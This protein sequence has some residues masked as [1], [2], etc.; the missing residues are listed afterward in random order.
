M[1][2]TEEQYS[3]W[4]HHLQSLPTCAL[5]TTGRTGSDFLQ[6]LLD[7]HPQV[8][9]FNGHFAVY[10]EFFSQST[11]LRAGSVSS[12]DLVDEFVGKYIYKLVSRYDIQE[13]KD[14]L[15]ADCNQ[16]FS[17]D[18]D[19]FRHHVIGLLGDK[20]ATTR[21][22]LLAVYGAYSLCLG[23]DLEAKRIIFHHPHLIYELRLFL[24]DFPNSSVIFTTR[25]PR[26]NFVSHV[27]HFR[28][29]YQESDNEQHLYGCLQMMLEDSSPGKL[30]GLRYTA[31][32]L[33]DLPKESTLLALS[34]W[35]G[36]DY[37]ETLLHSTWAGLDWHG[38][39]LSKRIFDSKGWSEKRTE[40]GWVNR[41]GKLEHYIF[42]FIMQSRLRHYGYPCRKASWIDLIA[43][44]LLIPFPMKYERR[45]LSISHIRS[46]LRTKSGIV[47]LQFLLTPLFY[48][49]RVA[50]CY[51]FY[52][53][54]AR[55][56]TFDG[57]WIGNP[58]GSK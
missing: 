21:A 25:D 11:C 19:E 22:F 52:F 7:S 38:D 37:S 39:R 33:E 12:R 17:L 16:S 2:V 53:R 9:T 14:R 43:V 54:E 15:G 44:F 24:A 31:V 42:N 57:N 55:G 40:N 49:K 10:S 56:E 29:Y 4:M 45:F 27:E 35:L 8:A 26:A 36:I 47:R 3:G 13:S 50:L 18:T 51:Q 34:N 5:V 28:H 23:Q 41:L 46:V 30:L 58:N 6:S 32:R 20:P 48:L 1:P